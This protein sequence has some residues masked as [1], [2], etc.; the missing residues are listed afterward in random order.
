MS[1][2]VM[3]EPHPNNEEVVLVL[4]ACCSDWGMLPIRCSMHHNPYRPPTA[5]CNC[6]RTFVQGLLVEPFGAPVT[7]KVIYLYGH[8]VCILRPTMH[9]VHFNPHDPQ[10][11]E[12]LS[13][14]IVHWLGHLW[15]SKKCRAKYPRIA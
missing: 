1:L 14:S 9:V 13:R 11:K 8:I 4:S 5:R 6:T 7:R 10:N 2:K 15:P 3:W 12:K